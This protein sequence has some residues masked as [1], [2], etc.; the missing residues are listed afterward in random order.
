MTNHTRPIH[1]I[2]HHW[3]LM[4]LGWTRRHTDTHILTRKPKQFQETGCTWPLAAHT[5]FKNVV[6]SCHITLEP[7]KCSNYLLL[8]MMY[9]HVQ[10]YTKFIHYK[11][12]GNNIFCQYYLLI[13]CHFRG[14][15]SPIIFCQYGLQWDSPRFLNANVLCYTVSLKSACKLLRIQYKCSL[16]IGTSTK[17]FKKASKLMLYKP[18]FLLFMQ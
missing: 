1:T 12:I 5:W 6:I 15:Q 8:I 17:S 16:L 10:N 9:I 18:L 3:L 4:P 2:S 11:C 7:V 13:I 14:M